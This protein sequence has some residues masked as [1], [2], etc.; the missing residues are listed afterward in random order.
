[1]CEKFFTMLNMN[2]WDKVLTVWKKKCQWPDCS[3][4]LTYLSGWKCR[5][6]R[7]E[8]KRPGVGGERWRCSTVPPQFEVLG[9]RNCVFSEWE[10][11]FGAKWQSVG[12]VKGTTVWKDTPL[13]PERG[14]LKKKKKQKNNIAHEPDAGFIKEF[15]VH[16]NC[17][18]LKG[19]GWFCRLTAGS[20][21]HDGL[22]V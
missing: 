22:S 16:V 9:G 21:F 12:G 11:N 19:S 7:R 5:T 3:S 15:Y 8:K 18:S 10:Q 4:E 14:S 2:R 20:R 17:S 13:G 1:M 6:R